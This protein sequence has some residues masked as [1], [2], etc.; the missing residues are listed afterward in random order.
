MLRT[1]SKL[2]H[3]QL[4]ARRHLDSEYFAG[5]VDTFALASQYPMIPHPSG[6]GEGVTVS[7]L[8]HEAKT[9]TSTVQPN[10]TW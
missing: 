2:G 1:L 4:S 9:C 6:H 10:L 8:P 3:L 5:I 7:N